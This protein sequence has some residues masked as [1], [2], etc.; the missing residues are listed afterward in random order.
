M[1]HTL[2]HDPITHTFALMKLL[3]KFA[4][5]DSLPIPPTDRR[6]DTWDEVVAFLPDVLNQ[7]E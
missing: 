1:K 6:F 3:E 5:G 4:D 2:H 7:D